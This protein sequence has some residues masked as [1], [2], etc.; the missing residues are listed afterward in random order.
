MA[1]NLKLVTNVT[2]RPFLTIV[3]ALQLD[4]IV[5]S[6]K[7]KATRS[8]SRGGQSPMPAALNDG[9]IPESSRNNTLA[10]LAGTM[11]HRGMS[12]AAIIAALQAENTANCR[13]PLDPA[14]VSAIATSIIRYPAADPDTLLKSLTDTGNAARFAAR[15]RDHARFIYG[16]GWVIWNELRWRQD[17]TGQIM[18]LAKELART[19]HL[20]AADINDAA[21]SDAVRKHAKA[22]LQ[23]PKL[24]AMLDLA[25]SEPDLAAESLKLDS[26]DLLLGVANGVINLKTG[27]LQPAKREDMLTLHSA[28]TFDA[29]A[30]CHRF[31]AFIDQVT[32][33]DR[34]LA[35]YLQ[36]VV[37]YS[38]TGLTTEQCL[39]FLYGKGLNGKST[40]LSVIKA[41]VGTDFAKQTPSETLMAKRTS[42]TN[43]IARLQNVRVVI[44][45]EVEDGSLLAESLVK[46]VTGGES[47][48]AKF[49][50]AEYFEFMPKF[51][52]FI[53]G[54]HKP[55]IRGRD[56]GIWRRIRLVP[57]V[58]TITPAQKDPYL[59]EKLVAELPGILNWAI[60]GC[61]DWQKNC[62]REPKVV[63]D[64]VSSYREE[65][66]VIGQW[67]G[68]CCTVATNLESKAGD[69]YR[70]YKFWTD[71]NGYKAMA[72]G[73]FGR[74]FG[75]RFKKVKRKDGNYFLGI[76]CG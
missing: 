75:D 61:L 39:F 45:N 63:T 34:Q 20:E 58:V 62:L 1:A 5:V 52:L 54:N 50:Y 64:A 25:E 67:M 53:A 4:K 40:F 31:I 3:K 66:D 74:D 10:S 17:A 19:I 7:G 13:P 46:Q 70:S 36:R 12:E 22:S 56:D 37:G 41:L 73:T 44:A 26:H 60:K 30:Q 15:Y 24:K 18:E 2:R 71:Q 42:G 8:K 51:K 76:K 28:V 11:R 65:M 27:K 59:Q 38:L 72:A 29:K 43:D 33:G 14:E 32:G 9:S 49:H 47:V 21:I 69:A 48:A 57:F 6:D 68:E 35:N 55:T 23:A 16:R